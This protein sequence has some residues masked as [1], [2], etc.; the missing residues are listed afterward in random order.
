MP[1]KLKCWRKIREQPKSKAWIEA[2]YS[3]VSTKPN[4]TI[5]V[6]EEDKSKKIF[7][8]NFRTWIGKTDGSDKGR[9]NSFETR[10]EALKFAESYMRK[11]DK[12]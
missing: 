8:G 4:K 12:C 5:L 1:K 9:Y 11:H 6:Y 10:P 2:E 3:S 7:F